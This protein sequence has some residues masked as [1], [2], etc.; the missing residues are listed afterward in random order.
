MYQLIKDTSV[1]IVESFFLVGGI[2]TPLKNM[3][4]LV[5]IMTFP[6]YGKS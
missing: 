1:S 5:E 4:S 6:V 2:P 3:S